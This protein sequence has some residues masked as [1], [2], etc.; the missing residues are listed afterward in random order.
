MASF[1]VAAPTSLAPTFTTNGQGGGLL[2]GAVNWDGKLPS[3]AADTYSGESSLH[4]DTEAALDFLHPHLDTLNPQCITVTTS[5]NPEP[6]ISSLESPSD[7]QECLSDGQTASSP[8]LPDRTTP[9]S[10]LK[11]THGS[12]EADAAPDQTP[13]STSSAMVLYDKH[14][15][16]ST[17]M[18]PFFSGQ[19]TV[20]QDDLANAL[21]NQSELIALHKKEIKDLQ[22]SLAASEAVHP[23]LKTAAQCAYTAASTVATGRNAWMLGNAVLGVGGWLASQVK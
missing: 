17:A 21:K 10:Y 16:D 2:L 15:D 4:N 8:S 1:T 5:F 3:N 19:M 23:W 11:D 20:S 9:G 7:G 22:E 18:V 13:P 14:S 12:D 6:P